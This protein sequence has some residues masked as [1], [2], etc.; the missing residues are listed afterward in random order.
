[1]VFPKTEIL[2]H[3]LL[4][5]L[6]LK[7]SCLFLFVICNQNYDSVKNSEKFIQLGW[8]VWGHYSLLKSQTVFPDDVGSPVEENN[9]TAGP[10]TFFA[11][12]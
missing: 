10:L 1:M 6:V 8:I 7:V 2:N 11:C 9:F 3:L 5:N 4:C 12:F